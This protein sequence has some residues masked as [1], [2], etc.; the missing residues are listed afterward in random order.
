VELYLEK[1]KPNGVVTYHLSNRYLDLEPQVGKIAQ[2]L[3]LACYAETDVQLGPL[4]KYPSQ[5]A[6]LARSPADLGSVARDRR[7]KPCR[8][9]D[10]GEWRDDHQNLLAALRWH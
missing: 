3:G 6:A 9:A 10:S 7:W 8:V 4:G 5:W 1:L 2:A